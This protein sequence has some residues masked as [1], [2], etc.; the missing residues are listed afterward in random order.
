MVA[1]LF[2]PRHGHISFVRSTS[3]R[4]KGGGNMQIFW[5]RGGKAGATYFSQFSMNTKLCFIIKHNFSIHLLIKIC[6]LNC[7]S[8]N[9]SQFWVN[10]DYIWL[11][12][13]L[14]ITKQTIQGNSNR[15][16]T[17]ATSWFRPLNRWCVKIWWC[18]NGPL[19]NLKTSE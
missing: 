5:G 11:R 9:F 10:Y 14:L 2:I 3:E 16:L 4:G 12:L 8:I 19:K 7:Q 6:A 1:G 15:G 13:S 17:A 18:I